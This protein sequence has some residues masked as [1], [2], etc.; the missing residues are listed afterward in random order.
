MLRDSTELVVTDFRMQTAE[1]RVKEVSVPSL[2]RAEASLDNSSVGVKG[3]S[4][5]TI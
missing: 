4:Y 5:L 1:L 2:R 3:L